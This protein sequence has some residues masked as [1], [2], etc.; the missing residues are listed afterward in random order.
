MMAF[1]DCE[2]DLNAKE[3]KHESCCCW[4]DGGYSA[5]EK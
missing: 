4:V 1:W 5:R 3:A 2:K